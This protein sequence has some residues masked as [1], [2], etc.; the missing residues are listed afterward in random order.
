MPETAL[1]PRYAEPR[2]VEALA[3]SPVVLI[4]G[5]RQVGK[6]TLARVVGEP[7]GYAYVSFDDDVARGAAEA[8]PVGFVADLPDRAILDEV[9]RVPTL[10]TALKTAVDRSRKAG[11]FMLTGSTNV[12]LVPN[13]ADSLA[14]RMAILRLYPLAQCELERRASGF[15]DVL[16]EGRFKIRRTE[17]LAHRLAERIVAGGYPAALTRAA[18][19]RR[20]AWYRD[21]LDALV[22]RDVRDL[23]RVSSL[24][25]L[26]RLLALAAA[27]TARLLNVSDLA[28][29]F[30]LSRPTIRDYVT[31]LERVFLLETLPPWHSNRLSRLI[32]TPK[33]HVGDTGLACA[34]LGVDAVA[35]AADR[36][37]LGQ[38]LETFVFQE[39]R[40]QA[41]WHE[42]PLVFFH[43]RDKDGIEVDIV[44]ERG[45]RVLAG[46][47]VKAAATV[48]AADFSGLRKLR[49]AAGKRFAAGVVLYDGET[50][51]SFGEGLHAVPL[52]ALWEMT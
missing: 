23:A 50:S 18:V 5:P 19:R 24:D 22:Q 21:Y 37:L 33:L 40:R 26:P 16:F 48:T 8:D 11:R 2:L 13:L 47:E 49:D 17:R 45:A 25:A 34:L 46:V 42:E 39:L 20:A 29:P 31:L 7:R 9:Q 51:A 10:F 44:I 43:Y 35:V 27:Q 4:H 36:P 32:K 41:S 38:L 6:T 28:A 30:Q 52:R 15:L 1:Y 12:L 3:D 14:G